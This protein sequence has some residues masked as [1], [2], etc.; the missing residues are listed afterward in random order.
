M[1]YI[2]SGMSSHEAQAFRAGA[3]DAYDDPPELEISSGTGV[4]CRH[5]M[6]I[7][8][9]GKGV[10]VFAYRP[11]DT[12]HP[13]AETGPIFL[14]EAECSAPSKTE[15]PEVLKVSPNYLIKGYTAN[16]RIKYGTGAIVPQPDTD[17]K[18]NELLDDPELA[19]V[20]IRSAKNNCWLARVT[21][22]D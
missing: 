10:L 1:T 14:C 2:F 13:Y 16:Q 21:R 11:F 18:L 9:K 15:V 20:D 22:S 5:C 12:L 3:L 4:P 19:F 6:K 7:V 17:A 8:P